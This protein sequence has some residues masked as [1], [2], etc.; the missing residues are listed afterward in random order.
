MANDQVIEDILTSLVEHVGMQ[1]LRVEE[2]SQRSRRYVLV[3]TRPEDEDFGPGMRVNYLLTDPM[4]ADL[5][6]FAAL[7]EDVAR[8][9]EAQPSSGAT[10]CSTNSRSQASKSQRFARPAHRRAA[11]LAGEVDQQRR[12]PSH[13]V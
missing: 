7:L 9:M 3:A 10:R 8:K 12:Q 2:L 11:R 1:M 13:A 4:P 6:T 5:R